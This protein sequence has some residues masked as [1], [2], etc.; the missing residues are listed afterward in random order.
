MFGFRGL[1]VGV[2]GS[3]FFSYGLELQIYWVWSTTTS[4]DFTGVVRVSV[5]V[6]RVQGLL[7]GAFC[8]KRG[9]LR[10]LTHV[11]I[12]LHGLGCQMLGIKL[13]SGTSAR[14]VCAVRYGLM[15]RALDWQ[16]PDSVLRVVF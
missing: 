2:Q 13:S 15:S 11:I 12:N 1:G 10:C 4:E 14:M 7:D 3:G 6:C 9:Y 8:V 5:G 16:T